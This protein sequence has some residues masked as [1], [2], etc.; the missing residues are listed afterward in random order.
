MKM[1][2]PD[3]VCAECG[4]NRFKFPKSGI[5]AVKC[6]DCGT[7]VASREELEDKIVNGKPRKESHAARVERHAREVAGS[8]DKLRASVAATDRLIVA[9]NEMILRHREEDNENGD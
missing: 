9:S 3:L 2:F 4:S 7:S 8:H 6:D 1:N 5:V